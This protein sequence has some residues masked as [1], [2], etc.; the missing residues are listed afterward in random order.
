MSVA[1]RDR[2]KDDKPL[3]SN[4]DEGTTVNNDNRFGRTN[5]AL[6]WAKGGINDAKLYIYAKTGQ[7]NESD[8]RPEVAEAFQK[9]D[10]YREQ[11]DTLLQNAENW[12]KSMLQTW[13]YQTHFIDSLNECNSVIQTFNKKTDDN[14]AEENND[15]NA[16]DAQNPNDALPDNDDNEQEEKSKSSDHSSPTISLTNNT[17]FAQ[18]VKGISDELYLDQQ[19][20]E[21]RY[22]HASKLLVIPLRNILDHEIMHAMDM[23]R[24][25]IQYK[26]QFDNCCTTITNLKDKIEDID[27]PEKKEKEQQ[28][29][30]SGVGTFGKLKMGFG[31]LITSTPTRDELSDKLKDARSQLPQYV[32]VFEESRKQLLESINIIEEK[33]NIEVV[34][35]VQQFYTFVKEWKTG[36][37]SPHSPL[38]G[39]PLKGN[40]DI[41]V[42]MNENDQRIEEEE[43]EEE[44]HQDQDK[45][46]IK[47]NGDVQEIQVM[48]NKENV[49]QKQDDNNLISELQIDS[50][51]NNP[52]MDEVNLDSPKIAQPQGN[53]DNVDD[54][55]NDETEENVDIDEIE[56]S[57][58]HDVET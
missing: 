1:K 13:N 37:S 27:N 5:Q 49:E 26:R 25:Y 24:K 28:E 29:K 48:D 36:N 57:E 41:N 38:K 20:S 46:Q 22:G 4:E 45:D 55:D 33:L 19:E 50:M 15:N 58:N 7:I 34:Y 30:N 14:K 10:T 21:R 52:D 39:I 23:K 2:G 54:V 56:I 12:T 43:E 31:K 9:L 44:E 40:N 47:Q 11:I 18:I 16:D 53:N 8:D 3:P 6:K 32:K 17:Q 51:I 35:Y 42:N